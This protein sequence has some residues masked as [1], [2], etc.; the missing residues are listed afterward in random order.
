MTTNT[1]LVLASAASLAAFLALR[2]KVGE[3]K[4]ATAS[5]LGG[6]ILGALVASERG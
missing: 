5:V 2:P 1:K 3:K 4:A 6:V